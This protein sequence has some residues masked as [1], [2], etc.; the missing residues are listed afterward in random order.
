MTVMYGRPMQQNKKIIMGKIVIKSIYI[1]YV[2]IKINNVCSPVVWR[3][4]DH[5]LESPAHP[6]GSQKK[7]IS[8]T[9]A[10]V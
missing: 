3:L 7:S 1:A 8:H 4:A 2:A 5:P 9:L 6:K 10:H